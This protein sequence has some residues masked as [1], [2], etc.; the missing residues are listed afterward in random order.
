MSVQQEIAP[1]I[2][3]LSSD[4]DCIHNSLDTALL[5]HYESYSQWDCPE[6]GLLDSC[7]G[8]Q[9]PSP[10]APAP[11][12]QLTS[13]TVRGPPSNKNI[14]SNMVM[15]LPAPEVRATYCQQGHFALV[16]G[17]SFMIKMTSKTDF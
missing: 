2:L 4:T 13:W 12:P 15:S 8:Q 7:W 1:G 10:E 6:I 11:R 9:N 16:F 3:F 14:T 17:Q 5:L